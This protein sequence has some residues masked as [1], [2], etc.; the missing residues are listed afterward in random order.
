[1]SK[2][3]CLKFK[4]MDSGALLGFADIWV[5]KM[6]IEIFG[7]GLYAKDGRKWINFPCREY[8]DENGDNQWIPVMRFRSKE[9][10]NGFSSLVIADI[11]EWRE[12]NEQKPQNE[13]KEENISDNELPF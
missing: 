7:C 5:P 10:M 9:H 13:Q 11:A 12:Q 2:V 6:G 8:K 4:S 1:M 3:E